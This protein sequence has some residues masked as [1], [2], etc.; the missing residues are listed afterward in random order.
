MYY[1]YYYNS[2]PCFII[3]A[4]QIWYFFGIFSFI[5]NE[6]ELLKTPI[7]RKFHEAIIKR[8][9]QISNLVGMLHYLNSRITRG[10]IASSS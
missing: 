4:C 7:S 2:S 3:R 1:Y 6:L 5:L 9:E 10:K 8:I